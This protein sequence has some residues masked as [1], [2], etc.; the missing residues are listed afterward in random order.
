MKRLIRTII[1][2]CIMTFLCMCYIYLMANPF[3]AQDIKVDITKAQSVRTSL[4]EL[5]EKIDERQP[6]YDRLSEICDELAK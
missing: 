4:S 3:R 2:T 5:Q 6:V 1:F